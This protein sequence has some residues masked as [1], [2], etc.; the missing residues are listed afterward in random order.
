MTVILSDPERAKRV[1]GESK[2]PEGANPPRAFEPFS[3]HGF[4]DAA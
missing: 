1:E 2:D 3:T 4:K